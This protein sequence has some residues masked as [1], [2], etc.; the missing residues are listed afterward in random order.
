MCLQWQESVLAVT[1]STNARD[2]TR[3]AWAGS[4]AG[5]GRRGAGRLGA[6]RR[7]GMI[8]AGHPSEQ[9]EW[10]RLSSVACWLN[11]MGPVRTGGGR[12]AVE[13]G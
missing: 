4:G 3:W 8:S 9:G 6:A 13:A 5:C 12:L 10:P 11:R 1:T 2:V 7:P